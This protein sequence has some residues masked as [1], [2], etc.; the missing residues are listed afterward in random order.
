MEGMKNW[1]DVRLMESSSMDS[2]HKA[3]SQTIETG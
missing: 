1:L 2:V 3:C